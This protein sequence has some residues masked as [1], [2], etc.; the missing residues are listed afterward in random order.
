MKEKLGYDTYFKMVKSFAV[1]ALI[2]LILWTAGQEIQKL[3][4]YCQT[5]VKTDID[6]EN[7][8]ETFG[9]VSLDLPIVYKETTASESGV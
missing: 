5:G 4:V 9:N 6:Q 7:Y 2:I 8:S 1:D 3:D